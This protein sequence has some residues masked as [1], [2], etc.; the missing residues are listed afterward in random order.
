MRRRSVIV[1]LQR[2]IGIDG[3]GTV[4]GSFGQGD[5]FSS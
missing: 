3:A 2:F 4:A 1:C 5:A